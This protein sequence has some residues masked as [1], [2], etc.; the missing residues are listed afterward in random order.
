M[1]CT[2]EIFF[3]AEPQIIQQFRVFLNARPP[4]KF[5]RGKNVA[6]KYGRFSFLRHVI[7]S[8]IMSS[9]SYLSFIN[10]QRIIFIRCFAS[11]DFSKIKKF[12]F[13]VQYDKILFPMEPIKFVHFFV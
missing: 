9:D 5:E 1:W 6:T 12:T 10:L 8:N 13:N 7:K 11:L 3:F 2:M 4:K